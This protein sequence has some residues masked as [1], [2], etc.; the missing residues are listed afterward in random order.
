MIGFYYLEFETH[1]AERN[2][3]ELFLK[4]NLSAAA[5]PNEPSLGQF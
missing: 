5:I 1:R 3:R 4:S 2:G